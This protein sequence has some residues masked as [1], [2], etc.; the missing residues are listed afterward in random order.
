MLLAMFLESI[1][2]IFAF[3]QALTG[4]LFYFVCP[5][6]CYI[7]EKQIVKKFAHNIREVDVGTADPV[8]VAV[9][10]MMASSV[11]SRESIAKVRAFSIR[12]FGQ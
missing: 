2:V 7:K 4:F 6:D 1:L 9:V 12:M 3:F 11:M 5:I 10:S 8:S